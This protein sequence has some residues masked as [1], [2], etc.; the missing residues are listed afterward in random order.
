MT[1]DK[2][3]KMQEYKFIID[4]MDTYLCEQLA[5]VICTENYSDKSYPHG[6]RRIFD[7]FVELH[8]QY[9]DLSLKK[10]HFSEIKSAWEEKRNQILEKFV[11]DLN[12][13][14]DNVDLEIVAK[15]YLDQMSKEDVITLSKRVGIYPYLISEARKQL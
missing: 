7:Q 2:G 11:S 13:T 15:H 1:N 5:S 3:I 6:Y 12:L 8:D 9:N 4:A 14:V 10:K